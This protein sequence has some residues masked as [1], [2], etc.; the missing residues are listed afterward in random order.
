VFVS[1]IEN[2]DFNEKELMKRILELLC[3]LSNKNEKYLREII[4]KMIS[5]F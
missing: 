5:R 1:L 3:M 4:E 2:I